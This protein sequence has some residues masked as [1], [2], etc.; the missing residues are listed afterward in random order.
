MTE[1]IRVC[2]VYPPLFNEMGGIET[3]LLNF[4]E[5]FSGKNVELTVLC[6]KTKNKIP[7]GLKVRQFPYL[8][9]FTALNRLLDRI[10][11]SWVTP[12][13][14]E[15]FSFW[16]GAWTHFLRNKY[17]VVHFH[18]PSDAFF[19][20]PLKRLSG[21]R[22][23][24]TVHGFPTA[25]TEKAMRKTDRIVC[26]SETAKRH[27]EKNF[28][29]KAEVLHDTVDTAF[30]RPKTK[31]RA[32]AEKLGLKNKRIILTASRLTA[33]KG[34]QYAI[35]AFPKVLEKFPDAVLL[36]LGSGE[37]EKELKRKALEPGLAEKVVFLG[38]VPRENLPE[39]FNLAEFAV[40]PSVAEESFCLSAVEEMACGKAVLATKLG[41]FNEVIENGK[42]GFLVKPENSAELAERMLF[43]LSNPEKA[44]S[45]GRN[46]GKRV[47]ERF[48]WKK[49]E[50]DYLNFFF[51]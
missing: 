31:N 14:V 7:A 25:K 44:G 51:F 47:E 36:V 17:D 1:K 49:L 38:A 46:A 24:L 50:K 29:L 39:Y 3:F 8:K 37:F 10:S 41:A 6:G 30:F 21:F 18:Q 35:E 27:L 11:P 40:Q 28:N 32:L 23:V 13:Q 22:T 4:L 5:K 15:E 16:L 26:V 19:L 12:F 2:E 9:R 42:T 20:N 33:W 45:L 43:L 34:I 48:S